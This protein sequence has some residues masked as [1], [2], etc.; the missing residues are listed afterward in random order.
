MGVISA[1]G[2]ISFFLRVSPRPQPQPTA[3]VD[4]GKEEEEDAYVSAGRADIFVPVA[5]ASILPLL[6]LH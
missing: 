5:V 1:P 3:A 2:G 6:K 4:D